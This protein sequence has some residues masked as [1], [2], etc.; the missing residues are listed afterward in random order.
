[1]SAPVFCR[2]CGFVWKGGRGPWR[3][4]RK[5]ASEECFG[6]M[7]RR[8]EIWTVSV[9]ATAAV[10]PAAAAREDEGKSAY[11]DFPAG[12][13]PSRPGAIDH[14]RRLGRFTNAEAAA[15]PGAF[16]PDPKAAHILRSASVRRCG[17]LR[18]VRY[19]FCWE[20]GLLCYALISVSIV[21]GVL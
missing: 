11:A 7:K 6:R 4:L 19:Y 9:F 8:P 12:R 18:S 20:S 17:R 10:G 16:R 13:R 1:M 15:Y 21:R 5:N 3:G 2:L 14:A